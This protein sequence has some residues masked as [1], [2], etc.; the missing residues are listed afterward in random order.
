MIKKTFDLKMALLTGQVL[1][2]PISV[3]QL[4]GKYWIDL[5]TV[6]AA[7]GMSWAKWGMYLYGCSDKFGLSQHDAGLPPKLLARPTKLVCL[8]A[9]LSVFDGLSKHRIARK[10]LSALAK[11]WPK[12]WSGAALDGADPETIPRKVTPA[13]VRELHRLSATHTIV[14]SSEALGLS[15]KT[16]RRIKNGNYPM[17]KSTTLAWHETFGLNIAL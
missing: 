10:R 5:Q 15:A 12:A 17:D 8:L 11:V 2:Q 9:H 16:A 7:L 3:V 14:K 4:D 1:M 13:I 6:L